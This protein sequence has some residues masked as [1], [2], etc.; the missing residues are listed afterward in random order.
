MPKND[1][2]AL[3]NEYHI[4]CYTTV[5]LLKF[6]WPSDSLRM[7]ICSITALGCFSICIA[8]VICVHAIAEHIM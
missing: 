2:S 3:G 4:K 1:Y 7:V 8:Q 5:P 6:D